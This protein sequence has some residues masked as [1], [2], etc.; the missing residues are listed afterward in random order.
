MSEK[1]RKIRL[2]CFLLFSVVVICAGCYLIA[3]RIE[4]RK[5]EMERVELNVDNGQ[6]DFGNRM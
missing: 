1:E 6:C 3:G 2:V 4:H 5:Q